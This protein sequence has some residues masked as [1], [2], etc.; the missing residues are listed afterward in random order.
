MDYCPKAENDAA[1]PYPMG[2]TVHCGSMSLRNPVSLGW[3]TLRTN[4]L[5]TALE[6]ETMIHQ[7]KHGSLDLRIVILGTNLVKFREHNVLVIQV[8][9][10]NVGKQ[11]MRMTNVVGTYEVLDLS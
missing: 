3:L 4:G 10:R 8:G 5:P 6:L 7:Y 1:D 2:L 11:K 9:T